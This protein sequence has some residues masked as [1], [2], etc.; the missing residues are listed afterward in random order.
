MIGSDS[1][2]VQAGVQEQKFFKNPCKYWPFQGGVEYPRLHPEGFFQDFPLFS[3]E[4]CL[5]IVVYKQAV[6]QHLVQTGC[7]TLVSVKTDAVRENRTN[8]ALNALRISVM[9]NVPQVL[10]EVEAVFDNRG[11]LPLA[12]GRF[13]LAFVGLMKGLFVPL[14]HALVALEVNVSVGQKVLELGQSRFVLLDGS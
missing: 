7:S 11:F 1:V 9:H 10:E 12:F 8:G 4:H 13:A 5:A 6:A 14:G 3:G 2:G